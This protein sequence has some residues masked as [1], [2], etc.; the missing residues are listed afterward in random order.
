MPIE[1]FFAFGLFTIIFG[2]VVGNFFPMLKKDSSK[3]RRDYTSNESDN[4]SDS[5][6]TAPNQPDAAPPVSTPGLL[7]VAHFWRHEDSKQLV[8]QV[9][10]Q[11]ISMGEDLTSDQHALLSLVLLDLGEWVGLESR[12]QVIN[13]LQ[14]AAEEQEVEEE[15]KSK[16]PFFS[17]ID[18]LTKAV[19]AD[20]FLPFS[21]TSLADQIDPILQK[22]LLDSPLMDRGISLIDME[23]RGVVVNVGLDLYD[24]V[25]EVPDEEIRAIIQQAVKV[26]E[27]LDSSKDK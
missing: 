9:E 1:L 21:S 16:A 23:E 17:P 26:W 24:S 20:V 3:S 11:F 12:M 27:N 2:Y 4:E 13:E 15:N 19:Q 10:N 6:T 25:G 18:I 8:A 14:Q 7:D 22:L 5:P